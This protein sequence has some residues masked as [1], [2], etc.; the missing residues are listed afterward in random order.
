MRVECCQQETNLEL[1]PQTRKDITIKV[2]K[3][4]GRRHFELEVDAGKLGIIL[5]V[6]PKS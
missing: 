5:N 4:C 3:V 2:C 1:Q 6:T